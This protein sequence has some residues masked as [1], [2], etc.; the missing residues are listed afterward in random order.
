MAIRTIRARA[1]VFTVAVFGCLLAHAQ[2]PLDIESRVHRGRKR[3]RGNRLQMGSAFEQRLKFRVW[4]RC[5]VQEL[6]SI[7]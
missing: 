3:A 1:L 2:P 5:P 7:G 4:S 6:T